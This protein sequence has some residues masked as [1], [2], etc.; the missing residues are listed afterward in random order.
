MHIRTVASLLFS[1]LLGGCDTLGYYAQ[2][3]DGHLELMGQRRP[4]GQL[5]SD[6]ATPE[7]LQQRLRLVQTARDF[8]SRQLGL[9]DN[10]SYRSFAAID[11][12]AVVW[13]VVAAPEFSVQPREWCYLVIGCASYR[14]YYSHQAALDYSRRL[15]REGLDVAVE[16]VPAYS[17][18]GWFDDPVPSTVIDWPATRLVG[19]IFHELA[20]QQLYVPGDSGFNEAFANQVERVGVERWLESRGDRQGLESWRAG[21]QREQQ[22]IQLLLETRQRLDRL[23]RQPLPDEARRSLKAGEIQRLHQAYATLKQQWGGFSGYDGWFRRP[24]NNARLAL[25]ATYEQWAPVFSLLLRRAGGSMPTFYQACEGLAGLP[26][27]QRQ[28]QMQALLKAAGSQQKKP[29]NI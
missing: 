18:L 3:V 29:K 5:L 19:L 20:H 26:H 22:F 13:A 12:E 1:L 10:D 4:V 24:V 21:Q 8:A 16:A 28:Q 17:T 11:R 2:S 27:D 6:R 15:A 7:P 14:G 9:P 25:V 23:Y